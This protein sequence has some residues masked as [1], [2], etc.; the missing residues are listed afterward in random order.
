MELLTMCFCNQR[1]AATLANK[2]N[3][4]S[5]RLT[6]T[7][8]VAGGHF[9]QVGFASVMPAEATVLD[10]ATWSALSFLVCL[11]HNALCAQIG[12]VVSIA[13]TCSASVLPSYRGNGVPPS[14]PYQS[15]SVVCP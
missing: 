5:T 15:Y 7:Q 6:I 10:S 12:L 14:D 8:A 2:A 4:N 1:L 3:A 13:L 11:A 9:V